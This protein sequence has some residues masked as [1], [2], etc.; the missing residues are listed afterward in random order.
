MD[1]PLKRKIRGIFVCCFAL[2]SAAFV[3]CHSLL[4]ANFHQYG[5]KLDLKHLPLLTDLFNRFHSAGYALPFIA[6]AAMFVRF[7]DEEKREFFDDAAFYGVILASVLWFFLCMISWQLPG[8][9]PVA[10][11][12]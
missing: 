10:F 3:Q 11:I 9:F 12:K 2:A 7:R 6:F 5:Y 1:G 4:Q 8:Y